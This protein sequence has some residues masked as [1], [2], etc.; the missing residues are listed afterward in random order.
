[1][2][3][4]YGDVPVRDEIKVGQRVWGIEKKNYGSGQLT[5][6]IVARLLTSA[7]VHPRGIKVMFENGVV[8]RVQRITPP[9]AEAPKID[10]KAEMV[11]SATATNDE[12]SL[13]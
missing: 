8:A 13:R 2:L 9:D 6:G 10:T 12:F 4:K 5:E 7:S 3:Q 1:M 11:M